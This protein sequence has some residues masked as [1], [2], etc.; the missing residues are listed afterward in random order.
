MPSKIIEVKIKVDA[1]TPVRLKDKETL[2]KAF[3]SLPAE[4]QQRMTQLMS[5][6]KALKGLAE[7]W[8]MLEPMFS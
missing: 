6:P 7:N 3:S 4:D 1:A 2:L 8:Q 5:N